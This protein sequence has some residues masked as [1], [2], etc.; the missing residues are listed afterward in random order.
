MSGPD[1]FKVA[2]SNCQEHIEFP[3]ELHGSVIDCPHCGLSTVLRVPG[4]VSPAIQKAAPPRPAATGIASNLVL[5]SYFAAIF[6]PFVGF[7]MGLYLMTK[8]ESGHG[9]ACMGLSIA[10]GILWV[11]IFS[12]Q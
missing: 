10:M 7:F 3:K 1:I 6:L 2:C 5:F 12:Q 11:A 9:A 8:K 4:Y